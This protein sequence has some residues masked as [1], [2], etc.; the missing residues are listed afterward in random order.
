MPAT[1]SKM[2]QTPE[3]LD[4]VFDCARVAADKRGTDFLLLDV[5]SLTSYTDYFLLVS[6]SSD[7][8][9]KTIA[10]AVRQ[11]M[12]DNGVLPLGMEGLREGKWALLDFGP[13]IVHIFYEEVRE[14][15]DLEG[16]WSDA[17][18]IEIPKEILA[19]PA[20]GG[21]EEGF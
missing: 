15:F 1:E 14:A 19:A 18:R 12:K 20:G 10:E 8:R 11:E 13:W 2:T 7:R 6:A 5:A 9:V 16:L 21:E 4:N 17:K 3:I